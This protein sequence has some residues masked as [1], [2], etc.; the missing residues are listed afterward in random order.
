MYNNTLIVDDNIN[1]LKVLQKDYTAK[2]K[3]IYIDPPYNT[4]SKKT[5]NDNL[6]HENW[7]KM[8]RE[9]L[10]L[11]LPLLRQD[12]V[13][14][15]SIDDNEQAR[16]KILCDEIFGDKNY[17][18][19]FPWKKRTIKNDVP[20]GVS[21]DY[22]WILCYAKSSSFVASRKIERKYYKSDDYPNDEWRLHPMTT[23]NT[24][25]GR[26]NSYFT[27]INPKNGDE[28]PSRKDRTW[29]ATK[30][31]FQQNY[32]KGKIIFPGDYDFLKS[33]QPQLRVFKSEDIAKKGDMW[34]TASVSTHL[35]K[36][37]VGDSGVGTKEVQTLF[38]RKIFSFPKPTTLIKYL[39]SIATLNDK[40]CII[41]D[42]FAGSGTTGQA[43]MEQNAEDGGNRKYIL[44]QIP[45]KLEENSP[46]YKDGYRTIADITRER[47]RR[48]R[49]KIDFEKKTTLM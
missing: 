13:I 46:A 35:D 20:F 25:E 8:M 17:V 12:G 15:I 10:I 28:Y 42:F 29:R 40:E 7:I 24:A 2:I 5:Y 30:D 31:N 41:L 22:E 33:T 44:V 18:A 48:A 16:L 6:S 21:Q 38:G 34:D 32:D 11:A 49:E 39:V 1:A 43:V 47:L 23:L 4:G 3:M 37:I 9:R 26:P 27:M 14:F 36:A 19:L 45:E